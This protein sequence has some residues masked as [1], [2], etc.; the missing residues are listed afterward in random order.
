M[1]DR[2]VTNSELQTFKD[3]RRKWWLSFHRKLRSKRPTV[4]GPLPIGIRVHYA[5]QAL[6]DPDMIEIGVGPVG[7][8]NSMADD[9]RKKLDAVWAESEYGVPQDTLKK[10][11]SEVELGRIMVEGYL[12][13][14]VETGAD[15][16]F[17]IIGAEE[18]IDVPFFVHHE[19]KRQVRLLG[20]LDLRVRRLL[21]GARLFIDYKTCGSI[22]GRLQTIQL[23]EQFLHYQLL[24]RLRGVETGD[25]A[26]TQGSMVG[27]LRKVKRTA[28]ATP[29]FYY[30][31]EVHHSDIELRNYY[32]RVYQEV[33]DL[34][35]LEARL[36][37]SSEFA[38]VIAYPR[39]SRDCSWKCEFKSVCPMF[40]DGSDAERYLTDNFESYDPLTRYDDLREV[41]NDD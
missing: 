32:N 4:M 6:H 24:E 15:S 25:T 40:D 34:L 31:A 30:R 19:S 20:K 17:E 3:C 23:E 39:P 8:Y 38:H 13:W 2:L 33:N 35:E 21:D 7:Y 12:E 41:S 10:F 14:L 18:K 5:L 16:N 26:M 9:D 22:S 29:P 36:N 28:N 1:S 11:I 37:E 27:L